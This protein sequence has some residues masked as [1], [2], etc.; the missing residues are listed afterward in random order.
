MYTDCIS[1]KKICFSIFHVREEKT[2][3]RVSCAN[4]LISCPATLTLVPAGTWLSTG[5][6]SF[7]PQGKHESAFL[8]QFYIF[9]SIL[10]GGKNAEISVSILLQQSA[11]NSARSQKKSPRTDGLSVDSWPQ[12][13][14]NVISMSNSSRFT[15]N[16]DWHQPDSH[17]DSKILNISLYSWLSLR[18]SDRSTG[19][20]PSTGVFSGQLLPPPWLA[21]RTRQC[22]KSRSIPSAWSKRQTELLQ[23]S[24]HKRITTSYST[25]HQ[26]Q[27]QWQSVCANMPNMP[28]LKSLKLAMS[29]K[30]S[31]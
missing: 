25:S 24:W 2:Q 6:A 20:R 10:K 3:K 22:A 7:P 18:D 28:N 29:S 21:A 16:Q 11:A 1:V 30:S 8:D 13:T 17:C 19:P 15:V 14:L 9:F 31:K 12:G 27:F 5:K 26:S 4:V 23:K